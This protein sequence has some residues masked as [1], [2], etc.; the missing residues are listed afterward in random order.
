MTNKALEI[1]NLNGNIGDF[2]LD[3]IRFSIE[4]GTIMGFIGKNGSGKTTLIK[5][6][7]NMIPKTSGQVFFDGTPMFGN[8]ETVKA[9]IG[10]VF[11]SLIYPLNLKP[12]KIK[13]MISPFYKTFDDKKFDE[14]MKRFEL[15]P[16]KKL[17]AYSKGMQMKF[18]VVMALC[19]NPDLIILDE[20]TAGLDPIARADVIDLLLEL[21]Q[22][23]Q[24][25]ILFSTHITSDLEK[26]ADYITM[27]DNGKIV[28]SKGKDEMLD[29]YLL[30]HIE[31]ESMTDEIKSGLVGIKETTFGYEGLCNK[32]LKLQNFEGVKTA[33][34]TIEDIMLYM[35]A[36]K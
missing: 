4:K 6:I 30:A 16:S 11:D 18:G 34:P 28:F 20:P 27:I 32:N 19:H 13:K 5:T 31:R 10:V 15:N 35:G 22:N 21:M 2:S 24:R 29:T 17:K 14:L 9:K 7:L 26:I 25:S 12:I 3:D 36:K 33:R 8:E 1:K 23:E